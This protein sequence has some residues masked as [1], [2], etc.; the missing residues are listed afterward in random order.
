[1]CYIILLDKFQYVELIAIAVS[2]EETAIF[3]V[4]S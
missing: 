4:F 1:M 2:I 3:P